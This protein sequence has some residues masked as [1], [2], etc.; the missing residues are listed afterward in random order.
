MCNNLKSLCREFF[1]RQWYWLI[2][3]II[4]DIDWFSVMTSQKIIFKEQTANIH[5]TSGV[6]HSIPPS[7]RHSCCCVTPFW[8]R[9]TVMVE[10]SRHFIFIPPFEVALNVILMRVFFL[11]IETLVQSVKRSD[12]R[13]LMPGGY[14][15]HKSGYN[16]RFTLWSGLCVCLFV[17]C[18]VLFCLGN[19][20]DSCFW[21]PHRE[22]SGWWKSNF[23]SRPYMEPTKSSGIVG[24]KY[25]CI[26]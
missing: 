12:V 18:C 22:M 14:F 19:S 2:W 6:T 1:I 25:I 9:R 7:L 16:R 5:S 26:F 17:G 24:V 15:L 21:S 4:T 23:H 13:A 20:W 3:L 11:S 8:I 10:L